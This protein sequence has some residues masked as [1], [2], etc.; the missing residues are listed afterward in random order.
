MSVHQDQLLQQAPRPLGVAEDWGLGLVVPLSQGVLSN[1]LEVA[2]ALLAAQ[3]P[4]QAGSR[5]W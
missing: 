3:G 4:Q 2:A 1:P 5:A